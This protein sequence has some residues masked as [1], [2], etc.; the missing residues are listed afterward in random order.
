MFC[1]NLKLSDKH[2]NLVIYIPLPS[3]I[4]VFLL[5][6]PLCLSG[7]HWALFPHRIILPSFFTQ[8]SGQENNVKYLK[9]ELGYEKIKTQVPK[10]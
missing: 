1:S 5:L 10:L 7:A 3:L 2:H 6:I 4:T 9:A 8:N